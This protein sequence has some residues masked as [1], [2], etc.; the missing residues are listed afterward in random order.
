MTS[1]NDG[2]RRYIVVG[3]RWLPTAV[4]LG[5]S[6]RVATWRPPVPQVVLAALTA[7]VLVAVVAPARF[8]RWLRPKAGN[9]ARAGRHLEHS[10][11]DRH[12]VRRRHRV[13]AGPG[14]PGVDERLLHLPLSL[15]VTFLVPLIIAD[16]VMVFWR[17]I[18]GAPSQN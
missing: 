3:L 17:V 5:A 7:L 8:R 1:V 6:G 18:G 4:Y 11:A 15:L 13:P 12:P 14:R 2:G 10:G 16:H 9:P